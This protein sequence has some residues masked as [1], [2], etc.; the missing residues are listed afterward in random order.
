MPSSGREILSSGG[1][2]R[3][4]LDLPSSAVVRDVETCRVGEEVVVVMSQSSQE[5]LL[6]GADVSPERVRGKYNVEDAR[7]NFACITTRAQQYRQNQNYDKAE[8]LLKEHLQKSQLMLGASHSETVNLMSHL[9]K[10][11]F[12]HRKFAE[13]EELYKECLRITKSSLGI[14][15]PDTLMAKNSLLTVYN[16]LGKPLRPTSARKLGSREI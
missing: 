15:H 10:T 5:A 12:K 16:Q 13:A 4:R 6:L 9:A 2:H 8:S 1:E 11:Y 7:V 14:H 3:K